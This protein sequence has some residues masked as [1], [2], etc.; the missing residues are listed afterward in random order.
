[1]ESPKNLPARF[2][3]PTPESEDR[4]THWLGG[5]VGHGGLSCQLLLAAVGHT[6]PVPLRPEGHSAPVVDLNVRPQFEQN[7]GVCKSD[8]GSHC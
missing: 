6:G 2:G 5:N 8:D 3:P 7:Y 1:M 4:F